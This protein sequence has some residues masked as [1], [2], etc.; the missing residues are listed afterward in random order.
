MLSDWGAWAPPR[1]RLEHKYPAYLPV[2]RV[3]YVKGRRFIAALQQ[4][5]QRERAAGCRRRDSIRR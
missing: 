3:F 2:L 4:G 5:A 1:N